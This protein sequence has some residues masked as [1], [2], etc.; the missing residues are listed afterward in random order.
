[1]KPGSLL[2][3]GSFTLEKADLDLG[4]LFPSLAANQIAIGIPIDNT[5]IEITNIDNSHSYQ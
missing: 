1:M 2:L 5:K 4:K 3:L